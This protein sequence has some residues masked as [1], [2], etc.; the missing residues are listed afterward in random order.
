MNIL[1]PSPVIFHT[2]DALRKQL[3][4]WHIEKEEGT[5]RM[6]RAAEI[7][8]YCYNDT[9]SAMRSNW[10]DGLSAIRAVYARLESLEI[11]TTAGHGK[12]GIEVRNQV[13]DLMRAVSRLQASE[14]EIGSLMD[15]GEGRYA[16][17]LEGGVLTWQRSS[18]DV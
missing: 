15:A 8:R 17:A 7:L 18:S 5:V 10:E 2:L 4:P 14:E 3:E 13:Q 1:E 16:E 12:G 6:D 9:W 11:P